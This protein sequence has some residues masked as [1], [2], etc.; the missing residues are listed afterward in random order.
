MKRAPFKAYVRKGD[1]DLWYCLTL[2]HYGPEV[3]QVSAPL[4]TH[5]AALAHALAAVG[6][7]RPAEH[8]EAP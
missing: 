8:R 6:L 1:H 7:D 3:Q 2:T 5:E 4:A